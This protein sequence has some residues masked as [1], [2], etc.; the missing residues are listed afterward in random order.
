[1]S[2]HI[3]MYRQKYTELATKIDLHAKRPH[4]ITGTCLDD[5]SALL[6]IRSDID[7]REVEFS[8]WVLKASDD[9][10]ELTLL[11]YRG[12]YSDFWSSEHFAKALELLRDHLRH[13]G[14]RAEPDMPEPSQPL[15]RVFIYPHRQA[16]VPA[17]VPP[18]VDRNFLTDKELEAGITLLVPDE[19]NRRR[20]ERHKEYLA[21]AV[22]L[23]DG[24]YAVRI[25]SR[26][27]AWTAAYW[28]AEAYCRTRD[29]RI[30]QDPDSWHPAHSLALVSAL[31][32]QLEP[33]VRGRKLSQ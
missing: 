5:E 27:K 12:N 20:N 1:M 4:T 13:E 3:S 16:L 17:L 21:K 30:I 10:K 23:P 26:H 8:E 22:E 14:A 6:L 18:A 19:L 25:L 9:L 15:D 32:D 29:G 24:R 28:H 33:I 31:I 11:K 7:R 2:Y